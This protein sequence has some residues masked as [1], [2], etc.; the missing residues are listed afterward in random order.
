MASA[1]HPDRAF[2]RKAQFSFG[3]DWGPAYPGVGIWKNV[4]LESARPVIIEH[5]GFETGL[6]DK[7]SASVQLNI[8]Y[9]KTLSE[10]FNVKIKLFGH[11]QEFRDEFI[12]NG[13]HAS[14]RKL[15]L[16]NPKLWWPHNLG[17][18]NLYDLEISVF[19]K[20]GQR[21]EFFNQKVGIRKIELRLREDGQKC[22][23]FLI[24]GC[25][26]FIK[27]ANWIPA[28]SFLPRVDNKKYSELVMAARDANMNILRVWGGGIYESDYFYELCDRLGVMVWQ[29][30]MFACATYPEDE[31]FLEGVKNEIG[32]NVNRLKYHP[33]I[34][35]WCGNNEI[36]WI[37]HQDFGGP[38]K[39]M[40]GFE[41]FHKLI[42]DY[43]KE[44][45]TTRPYWP[46]SPSGE[47]EDP[48]S[49][50]SGNT[51]AWDIWSYWVDYSEV[52][53]DKSL[54]VSE[55]GFQAPATYET[56]KTALPENIKQVQAEL[57][58]FHNKQDDG[59]E[60]LFRFLSAHLPVK[61][62][63]EPFIYLTQLNQGFALKTCIE[64]WRLRW[65]ET[66]GSIL[67]QLND[68]W[69]VSSWS[70][71]DSGLRRKHAYFFTKH[72]FQ[73]LFVGFR[74]EDEIV[75]ALVL[76][77]SIDACDG[78]LEFY[79]WDYGTQSGK[80]ISKSRVMVK[81]GTK[82]V[83]KTFQ[84]KEMANKCL[85]MT[86]SDKQGKVF[87]RNYFTLKKWKYISLP[88]PEF[89]IERQSPKKLKIQASSILFFLKLEH[90]K[91]EFD[92]LPEII[93]PG[94]EFEVG[95]IKGGLEKMDIKDI[96]VG[97]LN[98]FLRGM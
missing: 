51:H 76:N 87:A 50:E 75:N 34:I 29:D 19:D 78:N 3:W 68:C 46:S 24:N 53:K 66:G 60:R 97:T 83:F 25:S 54:F 21:V 58:E 38:V 61:T 88:K 43:L 7:N 16:A 12:A 55:F 63:I 57:F 72:S 32:Q 89:N 59:S 45:D 67:W 31:Q 82:N 80:E 33:S 44:I 86:F 39:N 37:W 79:E 22:F 81:A 48:N 98:N 35:L 52:Y 77:D 20:H 41:I 71:I 6:I 1:R 84:V 95:L 69:P 4:Y 85:I 62:E 96:K 94:E 47:N 8:Q 23:K 5:V 65:P 93:L 56:F 90:A 17:D 73:N 2:I 91:L 14:V 30:F 9:Q 74:L 10:H 40:Q 18:P 26:L 70:I 28:D 36:E 42:P 49:Q 11:K 15:Q 27:G 13:V 64:H 92:D